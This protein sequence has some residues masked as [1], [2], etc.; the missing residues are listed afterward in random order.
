MNKLKSAQR[1]KVRQFMQFTQA[2]EKSAIA[3]LTA[4]SWSVE[5]ACDAFFNHPHLFAQEERASNNTV[6]ASSSSAVD[7]RKLEQFFLKY[8]TD[9]DDDS[10]NDRIGP[11]GMFRLLNDLGLAP[12]D[13][14]V[15]AL[16]WKLQA[17]TQCEFSRE[18][19]VGGLTQYRVDSLDKLKTKLDTLA[20][21]I[22]EPAKFR[23]LYQF[24]FNYARSARQRSLDL[25]TAIAYWE[26][27]MGEDAR[28]GK[29]LEL[30]IR[31]LKEKHNKAIPRDT[32]NLLLDFVENIHPDF[33]NYDD[34][35]AWPVLID[36]FVE[37]AR[38]ACQHRPPDSPTAHA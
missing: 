31:F 16:A 25:D 3:C 6:A 11:H 13:R 17:Q 15:L 24:T 26:I 7:G 14:I 29:L 38:S 18:E 32:W 23:E 5:V 22:R 34:E 20:Q 2:G 35:G 8:A 10:G 21:E 27:V 28:C 19:F 1:D 36:D 12:T 4:H 30:W 9:A 33:D 37:Y